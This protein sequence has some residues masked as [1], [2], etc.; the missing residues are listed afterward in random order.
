VVNPARLAGAALFALLAAHREKGFWVTLDSVTSI[1][2]LDT[3]H[4]RGHLRQP[5]VL[6][7]D[8]HL[9]QITRTCCSSGF[10]VY[11]HWIE[12]SIARRYCQ[13]PCT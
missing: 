9:I 13:L 12:I 1:L 3:H 11:V 5:E 6:I 4:K 7:V 10:A 2:Y 8:M